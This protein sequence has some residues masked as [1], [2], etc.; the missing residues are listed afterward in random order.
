M[1]D[2]ATRRGVFITLEGPDGAGKSLH[3]ERLA[4]ALR[5]RG[6]PL[7]VAR[8]PGGTPLGEAIRRVV[9]EGDTGRHEPLA[10]ALL[11]NAAR[12]QHVRDV[13]R[14]SLERGETVVCD[15]FADSTL[16]YQGYGG[17]VDLDLLRRLQGWTTG[18]LRPDLTILLDL[19]VEV[20]LARRSAGPASGRTR[21]EDAARF[22]RAFHERVRAGFL[23][24]AASEPERWRV[25]DAARDPEVVAAA[26]LEAALGLLDD[27]PGEPAPPPVRITG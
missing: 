17:G 14:P 1:E 16:A 2:G 20:G 3:T 11:F 24:L 18:D 8:E 15:R 4:T 13:L 26:V 5:E 19:P 6:Q 22:D 12:A 27:T 21:F 9:L 25:V 10:D 7:L 23:E